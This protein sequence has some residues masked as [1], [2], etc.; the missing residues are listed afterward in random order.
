[1]GHVIGVQEA[2]R[3]PGLQ[4]I[5]VSPRTGSRRVFSK[6]DYVCISPLK[7]V[8][9]LMRGLLFAMMKQVQ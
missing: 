6:C 7:R 2:V 3:Q 8:V 5:R 4:S 9:K 1:M